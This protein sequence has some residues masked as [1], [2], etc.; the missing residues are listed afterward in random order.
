MSTVL[1]WTATGPNGPGYIADPAPCVLCGTPTILRSPRGKPCHKTCA[2][3]WADQ[4]PT[5]LT[6]TG[7]QLAIGGAA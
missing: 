6:A 5:P 4:H 7:T 1:D 3:T 2:E